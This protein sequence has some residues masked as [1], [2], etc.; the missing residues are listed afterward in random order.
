MPHDVFIS[1]ST[2][3]REPADAMYHYIK[4]QGIGCWMAPHDVPAGHAWP[5]AIM[6]AIRACNVLVL[7]LTAKSNASEDV[8]TE[9][10]LAAELKKQIVTVR[11][12]EIELSDD[13]Q[14]YLSRRHHLAAIGLDKE[15]MH[16]RLIASLRTLL[17]ETIPT[18][19]SGAEVTTRS[20]KRTSERVIWGDHAEATVIKK[21]DLPPTY[22]NSIGM[23]FILIPAGEF[24]M[25]S[26][27]GNDWE[28][29]VHTVRITQ[30][31]Y[32]G[33]Y[34]V[35]AGQWA[36]V[37]IGKEV[38]HKGAD[39]PRVEV[40]WDDVQSFLENLNRLDAREQ[41]RLPTEAEWEYACR[42]GTST[43]YF[44][45]DDPA[46]LGDYAWYSGNAGG[47]THPVGKKKPNPWGLFDILG[48]VWEWVE[49]YKAPYG[50]GPDVDP[51]GPEMGT[52]RVLRGGAF[53]GDDSG[54]RCSYRNGSVPFIRDFNVGFRL[55]LRPFLSDR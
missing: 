18:T 8:I 16:A 17:P 6:K 25:G 37:E 54:C 28:K 35:T 48:N 3:D 13:L 9:V 27:E 45:G 30:P 22:T 5:G 26:E 19:E 15:A 29:P 40:S 11:M 2:I 39:H 50:K 20:R 53:H 55:V 49:D 1:Y 34:P 33:K 38:S 7:I 4:S 51:K 44:F 21:L 52:R 42:A 12:E 10:H 43:V 24:R 41:H 32:L 31:F 46:S 14:Y 23:E 36:R 47:S